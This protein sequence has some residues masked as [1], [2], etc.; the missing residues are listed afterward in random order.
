MPDI[1]AATAPGRAAGSATS[2][3]AL[4]RDALESRCSNLTGTLLD[5]VRDSVVQVAAHFI[6]KVG[7]KTH[8]PMGV[9]KRPFRRFGLLRGNAATYTR[10]IN[11]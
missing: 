1:A 11:A 2:K 10:P 5:C 6:C 4:P 3:N 7:V 9:I 8:I